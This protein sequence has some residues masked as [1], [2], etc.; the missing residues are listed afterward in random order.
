VNAGR[1]P[2][3]TGYLSELDVR[4]MLAR[5]AGNFLLQGR[6]IRLFPVIAFGPKVFV[7]SPRH[8]LCRYP[9]V[10]PTLRTLPSST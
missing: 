8:K 6:N 5:R 1:V 7:L 10:V 4:A 2:L 9:D 3:R